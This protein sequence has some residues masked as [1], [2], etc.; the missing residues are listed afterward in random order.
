MV[1]IIYIYII[2]KLRVIPSTQFGCRR[3]MATQQV[4]LCPRIVLGSFRLPG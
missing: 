4:G 3:L 2:V 1:Y